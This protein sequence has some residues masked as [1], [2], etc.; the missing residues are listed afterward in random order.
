ME[1]ILMRVVSCETWRVFESLSRGGMTGGDCG[2][3]WGNCIMEVGMCS[4]SQVFLL[5]DGQTRKRPEV[6]GEKDKQN[7]GPSISYRAP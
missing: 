7:G 5:P 2:K 3:K 4:A 1:M 6:K